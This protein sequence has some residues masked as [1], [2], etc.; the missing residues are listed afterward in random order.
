VNFLAAIQWHPRLAPLWCA[1][2]L[3]TAAA[4]GWML[5][6]RLKRRVPLAACWIALP[7][8]ITLLLLLLALFDPVSRL[9]KSEPAHGKLLAL[10][11]ASS[12]MDVA[13]DY[14]QSR[15]ARAQA[16]V[17]QWRKSLPAGLTLDELAFDTTIHKPGETPA[18][19]LRGTDLGGC[20]LALSERADLPSYLGV[21]LL[22]DGGD[23]AIEDLTMPSIPLSIVG[24]GTDPATWNDL[25]LTDA[26]A[27]A[28]AEKDTDFEISVDVQ[29]RAGH[30]GGFAQAIARSHVLL[31]H[32]AGAGWEKVTNASVDL[33]NLSARARLSAR[34]SQLGVQ[35]YRVT[36]QPVAG[37]LSTLNNSRT[38]TVNVQK[39]ALHVLYFTLDLGQEFKVLRNELGRDP[40]LSFSALFRS[41]GQRFTLQGDRAPGDDA[42]AAGFP[43]RKEGLK[44]YDVIIIGSFPAEDCSPQQMQALI[45]FVEEGGTLI[46]LGGDKSFGRGGYAGSALDVL[47]PWRLSAQEAAPAQGSFVVR[48]PPMAS[49]HPILATV[50][51]T[52]THASARLDSLNRVGELKPNATAL[53]TAQTGDRGVAVVAMQPFGKGKVMGIATDTLWKWALQPEP[54][55]S[56]YGLFWR[57]AVRNLTGKTEGGQNLAVNWDKDFYRPGDQASGEI[58][59][60]GAGA[61]V[62]RFTASLSSKGQSAALE[63]A[64]L[65]GRPRTFQVKPRFRDRGD[66]AFRLV[67]YEGDRVLEACEKSFP[68]APLVEE[69]SRL[70]LDEVFL[71]RVAN[72][73]GGACF[74]E[75]EAGQYLER[76]ASRPL[77]KVAVEE[78]SL[79]EAGPWFVLV[80]LAVLVLEWTLR[81]KVNLF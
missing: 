9:Q 2:L 28:T 68:I 51:D 57:Q 13:D 78:S 43:A 59:V 31:E 45:Q 6:R 34:S 19:A 66:Y 75:A 21:V 50:E 5:W 61:G 47:F 30:G 58:R 42:L 53:L 20:L 54:L 73:G 16:I 18:A 10:V 39:K 11:D 27:P 55:R 56:A 70:E 12:S 38:V 25:A 62:L 67:A 15:N 26:Q 81:R 8:W 24:I 48:V 52:V 3:L 23:E 64:P 60:L 74:S 44:P 65:P 7:K 76:V 17:E 33:S 36:V 29:A 22:T 41:A 14:R 80:F 37:E 69:G 49:G 77:R 1:A 4:W 46:F 40:G 63:V 72:L 79:V 35:R 71:K 32:A